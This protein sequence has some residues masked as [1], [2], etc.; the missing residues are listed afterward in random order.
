V[1]RADLP[2]KLFFK[3]GEVAKLTDVKQHVL[4]YWESEFAAIR[5]QKSKTNQRLYRRKDVE[6]ILAVK[7]L[8]YERKFTIE[9]ARRH[10]RETGVEE[11]L[12]PPDPEA[13]ANAAREQALSELEVAV[14][15]AKGRA[16]DWFH[17][18]LLALKLDAEQFVAELDEYDED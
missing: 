7:H 3:I 8:L 12:P 6:A 13:V 18:Q 17:K 11:S 5:P 1:N 14:E 10:L 9:G 16:V 15:Q 2:D 4:R